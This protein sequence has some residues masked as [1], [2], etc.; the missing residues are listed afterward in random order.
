MGQ[1]ECQKLEELAEEK[2][3]SGKNKEAMTLFRKAGD[4]WKNW[5]SYSKSA[6]SYERAYEHGM[7]AQNYWDAAL[8]MKKAGASWIKHG[9]HEKFEIDCQIAAQ[10]YVSAAEE[11]K[12]PYLLLDGAFCAI[13]GGDLELSRQL[14]DAVIQITKGEVTG[15]I[16]LALMLTEYR[17]GDANKLMETVLAAEIDRTELNKLRQSF[18]LVLAGFIRTSLESE[19]AVTLASLEESTGLEKN[20][21]KRLIV[22]LIEN[23]YIPAYLDEI[24]EELVVDADR[25]DVSSLETRKRPI[26]SRD[27]EDPGAWDIDLDEE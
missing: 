3:D 13:T 9:E 8:V 24:S 17:F 21:L 27:L 12:D 1:S 22:R 26:L 20:Q 19:A 6:Q 11:K 16:D 25:F 18:E 7:L 4:C 5:E 15:F 14:I 23:G 10:A 2:A